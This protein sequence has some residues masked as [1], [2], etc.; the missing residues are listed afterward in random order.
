MKPFK[1]LLTLML[2]SLCGSWAVAQNGMFVP[3]G[4]TNAEFDEYLETRDYVRS[5]QR[6]HEDTLVNLIRDDHWATYFFD[7][8]VLYAIEDVRVYRDPKVAE[9][10]VQSCLDYL[11]LSEM[12]MRTLESS[13]GFSH[14]AV[15]EG[16]R[17]IE[18]I[19]TEE[20]PRKERV[21][22]V[23]LKSTSRMHGPRMQTESYA[24]Q[25]A[26]N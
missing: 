26:R 9:R 18:L 24:N 7:E 22:T 6:P 10:I 8:G 16:E 4:Q 15:V 1:Y 3:F 20:G 19:V 5:L 21:T 17:I 11:K 14:Y 12:K 25:I 2:W 23:R 13:G